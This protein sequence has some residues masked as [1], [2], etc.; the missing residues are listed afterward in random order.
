VLY[1]CSERKKAFD[2]RERLRR[3]QEAK[4]EDGMSVFEKL[5]SFRHKK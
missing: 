1:W 2:K 5:E 3:F 4:L